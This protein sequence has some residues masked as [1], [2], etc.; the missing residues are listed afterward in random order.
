MLVTAVRATRA[1]FCRTMLRP[2]VNQRAAR[3]ITMCDESAID[4]MIEFARRT[5]GLSRRRFGALSLGAGITMMLPPVG[6]AAQV[7]E[8]DV[9]ITTPDGT[10]DAY[11]VHPAS[12]RHPGVLVWPDAL[13][14]RP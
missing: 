5:D 6:A 9:K 14:L 8:S 10:A 11:Y 7:R 13:G 2:W 4:D 1:T 12:C 3:S